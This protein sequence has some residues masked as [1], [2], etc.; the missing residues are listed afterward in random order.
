MKYK[1]LDT[2]FGD[3]K[4]KI[5]F[6]CTYYHRAMIFRDMMDRLM[7]LGHEVK[8]FNAVAKGAKIYE[9]YQPIM[10]DAVIHSECFRTWDRYIFHLKQRK[11][12]HSLLKNCNVEKYDCLHS[13]TLLNGGYVAYRI[14][15]D[16]GIHTSYL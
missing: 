6:L 8:A 15:K 5:L 13:H 16:F 14:K 11:I 10:D 4:M 7:A 1:N 3:Y 12:Y 2:N 9:K